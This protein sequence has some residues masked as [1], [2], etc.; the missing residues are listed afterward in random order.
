[1]GGFDDLRDLE[2]RRIWDGVAARVLSGER[3][4]LGIVELD[5]GAVVPEHHHDH[6]QLGMVLSGRVRFRIGDETRDL[7]PGGTWTI[8]SNVP[9]EVTAG[10]EGAVVFDAFAPVRADWAGLAAEEPR[11]PRWP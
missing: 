4:S 9:H 7:G 3:C 6:E 1:V 10:P 11:P 2:P 8:P 5:P